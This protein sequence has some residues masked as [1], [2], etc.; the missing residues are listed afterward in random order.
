MRCTISF[1]SSTDVAF[2]S[3]AHAEESPDEFVGNDPKLSAGQPF[4]RKKSERI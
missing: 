2:C 3:R 4:L 1:N